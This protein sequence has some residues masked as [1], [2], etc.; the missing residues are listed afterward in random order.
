MTNVFLSFWLKAKQK[1]Q[2]EETRAPKSWFQLVRDF[3]SAF[4]S[5]D[6]LYQKCLEVNEGHLGGIPLTKL[7]LGVTSAE[8]EK[9]FA[10]KE[11][12]SSFKPTSFFRFGHKFLDGGFNSYEKYESNWIVGIETT[13]INFVGLVQDSVAPRHLGLSLPHEPWPKPWQTP[14]G[15]VDLLT[16]LQPKTWRSTIPVDHYR[17]CFPWWAGVQYASLHANEILG[18]WINLSETNSEL[19]PNNWGLETDPFPFGIAFTGAMFSFICGWY[20]LLIYS[21]FFHGEF[22]DSAQNIYL[23]LSPKAQ[24]SQSNPSLGSS[25]PHADGSNPTPNPDPNGNTLYSNWPEPS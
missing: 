23:G 19:A 18:A 4:G 12:V 1:R 25:C 8:V 14:G 3:S 7:A 10:Q 21:V 2:K 20:V 24:F 15:S 11:L 16:L 6:S 5:T 9:H 22:R 17:A 13:Q